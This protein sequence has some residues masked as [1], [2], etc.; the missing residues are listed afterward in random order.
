MSD[1]QWKTEQCR[2]CG[3]P[4]IF[5]VTEKGRHMPVDAKPDPQGTLKLTAGAQGALCTVVKPEWLRFGRKDLHLS[6][7]VRCPDSK[8]WRRRR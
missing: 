2:S 1:P 7:F 3:E 6:H 8:R 5:C 4:I